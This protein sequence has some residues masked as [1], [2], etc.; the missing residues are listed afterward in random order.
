M[1][2]TFLHNLTFTKLWEVK[3]AENAQDSD[4]FKNV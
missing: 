4:L 1:L 3:L 2:M